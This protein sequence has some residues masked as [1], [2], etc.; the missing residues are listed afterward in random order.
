MLALEDMHEAKTDQATEIDGQYI[1]Q[2]Y[3]F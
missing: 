3:A 2:A 1:K